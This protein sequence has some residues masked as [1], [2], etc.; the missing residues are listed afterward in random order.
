MVYFNVHTHFSQFPDLEILDINT[1]QAVNSWFSTG[2]HPWKSEHLATNLE[3]VRA[4]AINELC[5]AIGEVGLD[6]HQGPAFDI[7]KECFTK[8][9]LISEELK[10]PLI[11]HCVK[12]WNE[13]KSIKRDL[14]PTQKWIFHGFLKAS[15]LE[16]VLA[17]G[18]DISLGAGILNHPK[19]ETIIFQTPIDRLFLETD[20]NRINIKEVYDFV[21]TVKKISLQELDN[22]II[23]NIKN[24]FTKCQIG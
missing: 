7:Q 16:D 15:I 19:N 18:L 14:K 20:D 23:S 10:L 17:E 24:T 6:K 2:I 9:I 1:N 22:M 12:A 4:L 21:A 5:M 11:I 3:K 13:L 8:M